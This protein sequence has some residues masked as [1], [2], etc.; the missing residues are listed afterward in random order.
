MHHNVVV[1]VLNQDARNPENF[2]SSVV[3]RVKNDDKKASP[4][5]VLNVGEEPAT[6]MRAL[7]LSGASTKIVRETLTTVYRKRT[8]SEN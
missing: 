4:Y 3:N 5:I 1:Y 2:T 6:L 8:F 7:I